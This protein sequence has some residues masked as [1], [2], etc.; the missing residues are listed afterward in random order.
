MKSVIKGIK[1]P[2][3]KAILPAKDSINE[4]YALKVTDP[5]GNTH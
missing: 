1:H 3:G 2:N 4:A 5:L